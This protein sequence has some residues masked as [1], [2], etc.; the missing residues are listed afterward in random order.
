M[1]KIQF[2]FG[3]HNHQ[4]VGNFDDV[5]H[6]ACDKSYIPF[7]DVLEK[8]PSI[9]MAIHFTGSLI[10][11]LDIHRPEVMAQLKRL[12]SITIIKGLEVT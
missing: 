10:E 5:F 12:A 2:I 4:P 11:W 8:H 1:K 9:S 7:M 3:I 6:F